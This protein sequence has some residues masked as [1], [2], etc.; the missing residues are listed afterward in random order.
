MLDR[1]YSI[2]EEASRSLDFVLSVQNQCRKEGIPCTTVTTKN[3]RVLCIVN[4]NG[5]EWY[6]DKKQTKPLNRHQIKV[7]ED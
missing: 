6:L 2:H 3:N 5:G 4:V 1:I 7:L